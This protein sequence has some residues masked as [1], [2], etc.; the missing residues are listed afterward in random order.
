MKGAATPAGSTPVI[1]RGLLR[2]SGIPAQIDGEQKGGTGAGTRTPRGETGCQTLHR[3][4]GEFFWI[5]GLGTARSP[6]DTYDVFSLRNNELPDAVG[7]AIAPSIRARSESRKL[8]KSL[9]FEASILQH[10]GLS[11]FALPALHIS[12]THHHRPAVR[13][14][15]HH[16]PVA[17]TG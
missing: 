12:F 9:D 15:P 7:G 4:G 1:A 11:E 13:R 2:M 10:Y 8:E 14:L 17:P 3:V 5:F 16:L 6:A